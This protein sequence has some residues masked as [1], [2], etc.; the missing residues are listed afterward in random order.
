[1]NVPTVGIMNVDE[2]LGSGSA[3][4]GLALDALKQVEHLIVRGVERLG[5]HEDGVSYDIC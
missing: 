3:N 2:P 4:H 1:M 5:E